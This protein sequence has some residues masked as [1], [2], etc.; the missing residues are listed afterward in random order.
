MSRESILALVANP[1]DNVAT[2][3]SACEK[4]CPALLI[5]STLQQ[6]GSMIVIE[7]VPIYHKMAIRVIAAGEPIIKFGEAMGVASQA[8]DPGCHVH[9]HNVGSFR[10]A[11]ST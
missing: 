2:L 5:D 11:G 6:L 9:V 8:I 7:P 1:C 3:L 4:Q 10:L